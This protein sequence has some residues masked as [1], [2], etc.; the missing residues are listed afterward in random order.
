M[1]L[2][3]CQM[4]VLQGDK[5]G[6]RKTAEQM[7]REANGNGADVAV[8]PEMWTC[9]Y[10]FERL[11]E[12]AETFNGHTV[13]LLSGLARDLNMWI[14]GGS[15]PIRYSE[16]ISN[17]AVTFN[18]DGELVHT[19]RK[20]HLIGLM[21]EDKYL[22]AG[23]SLSSF[24]LASTKGA[25]VICYDLRFPELARS[26]VEKGAKILFVPAEWPMQ[27]QQHWNALLQA[28]AIENQMYVAAVNMSGENQNDRFIGGSKVIDPWGDI[29]A[30]A[31]ADAQIL[32]A[33]IDL[34][35]ADEVRERVPSL[36]DRRP[37]LY[38]LL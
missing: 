12:H 5:A 10:D 21:E 3:L 32:L 38:D 29:V 31:G 17:T 28:R 33:D 18:S 8:L 1:K 22:L 16:G 9:G 27:R 23:D 14:V 19:Y 15:L 13:T 7:I 37:Q 2:A 11:E 30:E 4:N 20:I 34:K 24:D 35:L 26:T 6:N 25:T 36:R